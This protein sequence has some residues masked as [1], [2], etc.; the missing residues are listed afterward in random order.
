LSGPLRYGG[1]PMSEPTPTT[2]DP[3]LEELMARVAEDFQKRLERGERPDAQEYARRHPQAASAL[4]RLLPA[5]EALFRAGRTSA[6][7]GA[8]D[9]PL[10][11]GPPGYEVLGELGRGGMGVVYKARDGKL[12]RVVALKMI[13]AGKYATPDELARFLS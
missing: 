1:A 3:A 7:P 8:G 13:L 6:E 4:R 10:P 9:A 11:A 2:D 12:N 5:L